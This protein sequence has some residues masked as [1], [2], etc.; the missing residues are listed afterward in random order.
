MNRV[1]HKLC[2]HEDKHCLVLI[3]VY[4][5]SLKYHFGTKN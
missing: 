2:R 1:H 4:F 3:T 5:V